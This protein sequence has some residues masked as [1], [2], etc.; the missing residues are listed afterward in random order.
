MSFSPT[1]LEILCKSHMHV[2][3]SIEWVMGFLFAYENNYDQPEIHNYSYTYT[4][5]HAEI[6]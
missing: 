3:G 6:I 1:Q 5:M 4:H 2:R